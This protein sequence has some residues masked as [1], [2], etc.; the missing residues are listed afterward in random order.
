M[1]FPTENNQNLSHLRGDRQVLLCISNCQ[2]ILAIR[3]LLLEAFGYEVLSADDPESIDSLM[4]QPVDIIILDYRAA[5]TNGELLA[6]KTKILHPLIPILML[7]DDP[8]TVPESVAKLAHGVIRR[9]YSP[10][11]LLEEIARII[12]MDRGYSTNA[13]TARRLA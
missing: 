3:K 4:D 1:V 9:D 5:G 11:T 13:L 2:E 8:A 12:H 6:I 10:V 7:V